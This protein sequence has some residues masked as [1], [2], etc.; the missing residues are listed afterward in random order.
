MITIAGLLVLFFAYQYRVGIS[1]LVRS[2]DSDKAAVGASF[3]RSV[4]SVLKA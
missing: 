1:L 2:F 4:V 3:S